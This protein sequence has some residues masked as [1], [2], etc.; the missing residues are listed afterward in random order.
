MSRLRQVTVVGPFV[1]LAIFFVWPVANLLAHALTGDR[2]TI[3]AAFG[4]ATMRSAI[5]FTLWQAVVSTALTLLVAFPLTAVLANVDFPGRRLVRTLVTIP[6]VLPT[7]VVAGAFVATSQRLGLG[8]GAFALEKSKFAIIVAHV[9]FNVAV[10][11][12]TVGGYWSQLSRDSEHAARVLGTGPIG[13]FF[14]VTLRRLRPAIFAAVSIVFLF[15]FTSFGVVLILGGSRERTIETEIY[16]YAVTRTDFGTAAVLSIIQLVVVFALVALNIRLQGNLPT[17]DRLTTDRARRP[18][19]RLARVGAG[20]VIAISIGLLSIPIAVLIDQ[21][22]GGSAGWSLDNYRALVD[23][24]R[25]LS[26]SP[27]RAIRNS[28]G[29][30]I[31]A[32]II[33]TTIGGWASLVIAFGRKSLSRALDLGYLLPL[34]TSAVT[35]GFGILLT[36]DRGIFDLRQSWIIIP[37]AQAL[38]AT[39]FVTRA[40]TPVLRAIDPQLREAAASMGASPRRI[41][42]DIDFPIARRALTVGAGFAFAISLGEFGATSFVG[43]RPDLLTVPLAIQQ[44]LGRPGETIRG[45]AMALSVVLMIITTIVLLLVDRTDR[46]AVL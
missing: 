27:V 33:A 42:R 12:R 9:F 17:R 16:R 19:S 36:F 22:L 11:V 29:F 44:L 30:A 4:S 18:R 43:R 2:S 26:V 13:T 45:Q 21:S 1:F 38:V 41:R 6:F 39:P 15:T 34:G 10:I 25:F 14:G 20:A 8:D 35:L 31:V 28:L 37:L 24:P 40:V 7:V 32:A 3:G 46:S 5:W 23:R